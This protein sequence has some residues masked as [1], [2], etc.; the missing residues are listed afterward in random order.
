MTHPAAG[1]PVAVI[2]VK[3]GQNTVLNLTV[4]HEGRRDEVAEVVLELVYTDG[5]VVETWTQLVTAQD[6]AIRLPASQPIPAGRYVL[7]A[8]TRRPNHTGVIRS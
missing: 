4:G 5:V 2:D 6:T 3:D 8:E 7:R 1:E